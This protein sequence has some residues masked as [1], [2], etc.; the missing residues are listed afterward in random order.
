MRSLEREEMVRGVVRIDRCEGWKKS[1]EVRL[2]PL[3]SGLFFL[4]V[5]VCRYGEG[6]FFFC[7]YVLWSWFQ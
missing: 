2:C 7:W 1:V 6:F 5:V 3:D 4:C